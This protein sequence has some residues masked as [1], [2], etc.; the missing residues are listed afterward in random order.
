MGKQ[1]VQQYSN[2]YDNLLL[3]FTGALEGN[4]KVIGDFLEELSK[5]EL[6][7]K[8]KKQLKSIKRELGRIDASLEDIE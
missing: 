5:R 2:G 3:K 6:S 7:D 8:D 1:I 4:S